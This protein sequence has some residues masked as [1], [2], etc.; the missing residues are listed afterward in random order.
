M[1][2]LNYNSINHLIHSTKI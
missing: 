2:F 1:L